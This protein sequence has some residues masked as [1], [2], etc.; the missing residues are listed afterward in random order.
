MTGSADA[1]DI[2][3]EKDMHGPWSAEMWGSPVGLGIFLLCLGVGMGVFFWGVSKLP[4]KGLAADA[5]GA[6]T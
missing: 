1:T 2:G 5:A 3:E 4:E 6:Q